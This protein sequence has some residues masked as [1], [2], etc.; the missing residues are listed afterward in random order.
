MRRPRPQWPLLRV[1]VAERSMEPTLRPGDWLLVR[2]T[3]RVRAGQLVV[4]RHPSRPTLLLVKRALRRDPGGWWLQSDNINGFAA[5]SRSFGPVPAGLIEGVVL[6][7]Y[8][9]SRRN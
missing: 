2:R 3:G 7:R 6:I 4:A 8:R 5:D 9:R 1:A